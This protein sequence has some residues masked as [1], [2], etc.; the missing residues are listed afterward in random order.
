MRRILLLCILV[1]PIFVWAHQ[2]AIV[3]PTSPDDLIAI[4]KPEVSFAYYG[5]LTGF[6]HTYVINSTSTFNLYVQILE[7]DIE[8]AEMN[9]EVIIVK[10]RGRDRGVEEVARLK[11]KDADWES[12]YE[13]FGGDSYLAGGEFEAEVEPGVYRIEVSNGLNQGKYSLSVGRTE[14][15]SGVGYFETVAKI[16]QVKRFFEKPPIA[17]LQ[18][19]FVAVPTAVLVVIGLIVYW[20]RKRR[21]A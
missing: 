20:Y 12:F 3:S 2:P 16:Y 18:S 17:M 6:P 15:F 9:H 8:S 11:A 13:P 4:S 10:N 19:P 7:P 21:Y 14:D 5:E 1:L